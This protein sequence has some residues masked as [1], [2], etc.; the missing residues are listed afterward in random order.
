MGL[1]S[2]QRQS[3][4][5]VFSSILKS[6]MFA[7]NAE[8][9]QKLQEH[10]PESDVHIAAGDEWMYGNNQ[11]DSNDLD[12]SLTFAGFDDD[13][14]DT[15]TYIDKEL[16]TGFDIETLEPEEIRD[17]SSSS[18]DI[19]DKMKRLQ[20]V[21]AAEANLLHNDTTL[22]SLV[23]V[24]QATQA[25][26]KG[27]W[28]R[29]PL[30]P[31]QLLNTAHDRKGQEKLIE[32]GTSADLKI[33]EKG[34]VSTLALDVAGIKNAIPDF[35]VKETTQMQV[36]VKVNAIV[37]VEP[38]IVEE[39]SSMDAEVNDTQKH[40]TDKVASTMAAEKGGELKRKTCTLLAEGAK[41]E[42]HIITI[43]TASINHRIKAAVDNTRNAGIKKKGAKVTEAL[44]FE[45]ALE[46]ANMHE[47][48]PKRH[49][50]DHEES[51]TSLAPLAKPSK[52]VPLSSAFNRG[53]R[54]K[55]Q[56]QTANLQVGPQPQ[57]PLQLALLPCVSMPQ[58]VPA[59]VAGVSTG[60]V[61]IAATHLIDNIRRDKCEIE[62][63]ELEEL[64][65]AALEGARWTNDQIAKLIEEIKLHGTTTASSSPN[66]GGHG[67]SEC[68][69]ITFG[70]LFEQTADIFDALSGICKTAKKYNVIAYNVG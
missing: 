16:L 12:N 26:R 48:V 38:N 2:V 25:A 65:A 49:Q 9:D 21:Q 63:G 11:S 27:N 14:L 64:D 47:Q 19:A 52:S 18:S 43:A 45:T 3:T 42:A 40:V 57:P 30:L 69:I 54:R 10:V 59:A 4:Q 7:T 50:R 58:M 8:L 32:I 61:A 39:S 28:K 20:R 35:G 17:G 5:M 44:T 23:A 46:K 41:V 33:V 1:K 51:R 70:V 13:D 62:E 68:T 67:G 53:P 24:P 22:A 31:P 60:V 36:K 55:W 29:A 66:G 34:C 37:E 56:R 6:T 15:A